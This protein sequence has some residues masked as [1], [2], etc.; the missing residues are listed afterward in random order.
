MMQ[1]F[2]IYDVINWETNNSNTHFAQYLKTYRNQSM[3]YGQLVEYN[4]RNFFLEKSYTK[5]G[6]GTSPRPFSKISQLSAYLCINSLKF[7]T[8][9]LYCISKSRP[10]KIY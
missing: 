7:Y 4:M 3:K 9:C 8:V 5:Y 2:K 6:G 1:N 10:T